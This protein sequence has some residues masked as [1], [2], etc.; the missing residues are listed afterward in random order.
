M[1]K[2]LKFRRNTPFYHNKTESEFRADPYE[3]Y[4]ESVVRQTALHLAD[5]LWNHYP[6]QPIMDF[7]SENIP[8]SKFLKI[9]EIG[10]GVGRVIGELA[11]QNPEN[12]HYGIDFSYQMLRRTSEFWLEEKAIELDWSNKGFEKIILRGMAL[13][14][15]ELGLAKAEN[16]PFEN[17]SLDV[18]FSSFLIDR[19][20]EPLKAFREFNRVLKQ[21]GIMI[22]VS[23]LNFQKRENW[24]LF[25]PKNKLIN[26]VQTI[27][28]QPDIQKE[29]WIIY[30]PLDKNGNE[31]KWN[32]VALKITKT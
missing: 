1:K 8:Q 16:L 30:E 22:F 32:C 31:I 10:C 2:P 26:H 24:E 23:P 7:I 11:K 14:N 25:F 3:N 5:E 15:L 17:E 20:D 29:N 6:F 4:D 18:L 19:L 9:A 12:Y 27:G 28:F 13:S 21:D